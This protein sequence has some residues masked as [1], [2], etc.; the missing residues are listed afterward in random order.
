M[1]TLYTARATTLAG[2]NG[3]SETDD[4]KLSLDLCAPGSGKSGT[5]PEQLF[6]CGYSAC[7]GS[8]I[9]AVAK[10]EGASPEEIRVSAEVQ[11][12]Q[13]DSGGYYLAATL[14]ASLP[15][16]DD[17]TARK[18]VSAAHRVCP[19]SRATRGNIEVT[20]KLNGTSIE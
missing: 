20:I 3:R 5:N 2:R 15:G 19:Y 13:D 16:L 14:D 8:A 6:A 7:F 4:G 11:L 18:L 17:A 12:N 1:K 10:K 9:E